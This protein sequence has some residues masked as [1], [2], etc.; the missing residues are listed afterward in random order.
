[1]DCL[2]QV[3]AE[4]AAAKTKSLAMTKLAISNC[5]LAHVRAKAKWL[6]RDDW[7][8]NGARALGYIGEGWS[9]GELADSRCRQ[10]DGAHKQ[11]SRH[12]YRQQQVY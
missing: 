7:R 8:D 4:L 1:M 6:G 11:A 10:A 9:Q 5:M 12:T 3:V 2:S